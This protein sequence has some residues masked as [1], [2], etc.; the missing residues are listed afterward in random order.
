MPWNEPT[1]AG[2]YGVTVPFLPKIHRKFSDLSVSGFVDV[3]T[4]G[5]SRARDEVVELAILLFAFRPT[6]GEIVGV[7]EEY[8]GLRDPGR[9]IPPGV[10]SVHGIRDQ[11][12]RGKR[13]DHRRILSLIGE[14]EF[15]V[16]HNASFD[17][18]FVERLYPESGEKPWLCSMNG[19]PWK[20]LGFG[21]R[22]LQ[23][24]LRA[25]EISV[26]RAHRG[27]D[28]AKASLRLLASTDREGSQY[29]KHIVDRYNSYCRST[30][31]GDRVSS[32]P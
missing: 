14:A 3:E 6:T 1:E 22:G 20:R 5:L 27:A 31:S 11:D 23:H 4:T 9:P 10:S 25:H 12:V 8:S 17:R 29:F 32:G 26:T 28:D 19:V 30:A 15:L 2:V 16:A 18:A 21:S 7:V 24:L 13:L